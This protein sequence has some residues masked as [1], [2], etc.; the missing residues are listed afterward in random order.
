LFD[1]GI[2]RGSDIVKAMALGAK[3]VLIGRGYA[4]GMAAAGDVGVDRAIT[5]LRN[6]L[7]RTLKLLG[8]ASIRDLDASYLTQRPGFRAD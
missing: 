3:A 2:R 6:D 1:S 5:I 7:I 4:Y 8:C